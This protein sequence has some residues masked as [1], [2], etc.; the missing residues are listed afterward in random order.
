MKLQLDILNI[1]DIQFAD[2]TA[3]NDR[4]LHIN[5][6]ELQELLQEDRRLSQVGIELAHPGDKCR[7]LQVSDIIEPRVKKGENGEYFPGALGKQFAVGEGSTCVLRGVAV[8]NVDYTEGSELERDP[9]GEIIDMS[10]PGAEVGIYGKTH[11]VVVVSSP[12]SGVGR[13]DYRVALKLAGLKTAV[14]L[15]RAGKNLKP[16]ETELYELPPLAEVAKG[17]EGLPRMAY[18]FQLFSGQ[19]GYIPGEP[20][21]YGSDVEGTVPTILHPNEVLDGAVVGPYRTT[22]IET[23]EIQNHHLIKELIRRHGKELYFAG[24]IITIGHRHKQDSERAANMVANL[25]KRVLGA[26]GVV[27]TKSWGGAAEAEIGLTAQ[28]CEEMGVKTALTM[29]NITADV[30]DVSFGGSIIFNLPEVNA[31]VSMGIPWEI[32]TL[33]PVERVI[34]RPFA[35]PG[36]LPV[37]GKIDRATRWIKG[38]TGHLG[39]SRLTATRY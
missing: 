22:G 13:Q 32:I 27:L 14:Y 26:D 20:I 35:L 1:K 16:D 17:S 6:G 24:V 9:N 37:S 12:A 30:S 18:I 28:R 8:V 19:F 3:I 29:W 33:P 15:G 7:I 21:L 25:A 31:I 23:Y 5:R 10:G 36:G 11:N 2:K 38:A 4:V 39:T 34:G